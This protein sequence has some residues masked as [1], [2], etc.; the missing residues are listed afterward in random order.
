MKG[1]IMIKV[2]CSRPIS[3]CSSDEVFYYEMIKKELREIGVKFISPMYEPSSIRVEGDTND[4]K[5]RAIFKR[6]FWKVMQSDIILVDFLEANSV[7]IGCVMEIAW[8]VAYNKHIILVMDEKN[9][10]NHAFVK[11]SADIIFTNIWDAICYIKK[12]L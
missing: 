5:N 1:K 6:D 2:Y 4:P 3:G 7:S 10:H 11:E 8:G 12:L 9:I